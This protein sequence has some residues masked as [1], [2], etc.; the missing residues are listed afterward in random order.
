MEFKMENKKRIKNDYLSFL[1]FVIY[2][3][4]RK[5]FE[6]LYVALRG[7]CVRP[8][9]QRAITNEQTNFIINNLF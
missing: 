7:L 3:V 5:G 8:L 2:L 6:P 4:T 1:I 9:H